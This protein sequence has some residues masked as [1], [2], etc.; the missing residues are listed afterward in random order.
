[1]HRGEEVPSSPPNDVERR[2]FCLEQLLNRMLR[3]R[4]EK[5]TSLPAPHPTIAT[6]GM[7]RKERTAVTKPYNRTRIMKMNKRVPL[8]QQIIEAAKHCELMRRIETELDSLAKIHYQPNIHVHWPV[9]QNHVH[10]SLKVHFSCSGYEMCTKQFGMHSILLNVGIDKC[11]AVQRDGSIVELGAEPEELRRLIEGELLAVQ[12]ACLAGLSR[13]IDW[14]VLS[15]RRGAI[16]LS[17]PVQS[18]CTAGRVAVRTED[19]RI[20]VFTE[21]RGQD[22]EQSD[23]ILEPRWK[24]LHSNNW[25]EVDWE[26]L[27][28]LNFVAK[29][30][31]MLACLAREVSA[32]ISSESS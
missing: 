13:I 27:P 3:E 17:P 30:E 22:E 2:W 9:V 14:T 12:I 8:I 18:E 24:L 19:N 20:K 31:Q 6:M 5:Q 26:K 4:H 25:K 11:Q 10:T 1:M 28:G 16:L 15:S 32:T 29:M 7:T 21:S 23:I